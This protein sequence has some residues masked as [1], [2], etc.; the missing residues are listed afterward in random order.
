MLTFSLPRAVV[1]KFKC[2]SESPGGLVK[3]NT[4]VELQPRVSDSVGLG[5]SIYNNFPNDA[6]V[7]GRE[8]HYGN[9]CFR[10]TIYLNWTPFGEKCNKK[11]I[12]F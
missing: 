8:L 7:A 11:P 9:H 4:N 2:A 6:D 1:L 12:I 5:I 3:Q 10:Y